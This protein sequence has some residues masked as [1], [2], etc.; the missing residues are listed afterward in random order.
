MK[1]PYKVTTNFKGGETEALRIMK[2]YMKDKQRV[3]TFQKPHTDPT[4]L[5]PHTTALSPYLKFGCLSIRLFYEE[6]QK[7][8]KANGGK[9]TTPPE[10][11]LGQL[12]W[13][14]FFYSKSYTVPNFHKMEGSTLCR[15]ITWGRDKELIKKWE[16]GQT[17][18]PTVDAV[19][20]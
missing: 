17:G 12:Y 9:C 20:N 11:L 10:S 7:L 1:R 18:Y 15:Q 14:E 6:L 8:I 13:R 19:M 2:E 3:L 5:T 4:A 16:M